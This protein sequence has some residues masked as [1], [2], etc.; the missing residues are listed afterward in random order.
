MNVS[1]RQG[2]RRHKYREREREKKA[3]KDQSVRDAQ[4]RTNHH[5]PCLSA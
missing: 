3:E 2:G 5:P 4:A 1:E